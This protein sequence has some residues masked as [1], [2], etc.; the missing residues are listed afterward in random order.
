MLKMK[1]KLFSIIACSLLI[2]GLTGCG[3]KKAE[4]NNNNGNK[5]DVKEETYSIKDNKT[6]FFSVNGKTFKAGDKISD[7][8]KVGFSLKEK[9]KNTSI[10]K[11]RYLLAQAVVDKDGNEVFSVI[12]INM[13][14]D[15]I[16]AKDATIGGIEIGD[17]NTS[18]V[19]DATKA[20]KFEVVG[21]LKL[22]D[23]VEDIHKVLG[24]EDFKYEKEAT[25]IS[26][27][28]S[29]KYSSGY[30]GFEFLVDDGGKLSQIKWNNYSYDE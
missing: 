6:F 29:Y 19:S 22:G 3:D 17:Y 4:E 28:T 26:A 15:T 10:P 25:T 21:G 24:E 7:L 1:K 16:L 11:N 13:T 12:P 2:F 14:K 9:A 5:T 8:E 23:S 30:K 27:Y 20:L 18:K